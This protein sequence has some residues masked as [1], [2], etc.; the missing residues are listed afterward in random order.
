MW[1][2]RF[3]IPKKGDRQIDRDIDVSVLSDEI[4]PVLDC[5]TND[6]F[7]QGGAMRITVIWYEISRRDNPPARMPDADKRFGA[8]QA[9]RGGVD[10]RLVP[11]F[12]PA[13]AQCFCN[14]DWGVRRRLAG[15]ERG[16]AVAQIC[17]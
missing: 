2:Q 15:Q 17:E 9:E 10:L 3:R 12:D 11:Q 7:R 1:R 8:T 4:T 6:E 5:P 13:F 16:N 14:I